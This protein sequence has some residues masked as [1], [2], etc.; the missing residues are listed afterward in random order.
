MSLILRGSQRILEVN[1]RPFL[2]WFSNSYWRAKQYASVVGGYVHAARAPG[3][4]PT[5]LEALEFAL[6]GVLCLALH[7]VVIVVAASCPDKVRR[8]K[9]GSGASTELFDLGDR[10]GKRGGV[11]ENLL[12]EAE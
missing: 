2:F 6:A 7:I 4:P 9:K 12:V 11:V 1:C 8:R 10:V 5:L 3:D